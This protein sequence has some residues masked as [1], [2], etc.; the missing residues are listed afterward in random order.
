M[1]YFSRSLF[2]TLTL[3]SIVRVSAQD[4][5]SV[6]DAIEIRHKAEDMVK[7]QLNVLMNALTSKGFDKHETIEAIHNSFSE[8]RRIFRDSLIDVEPDIDPRIKTSEDAGDERLFK[9]LKDLDVMYNKT[10]GD[11]IQISNISCSNVKKRENIYIKVYFNSLMQGKAVVT[12]QAYT[13]TN[14]V[15]EIMARKDENQWHLYIVRLG[16]FRPTDTVGDILNN[17]PVRFETNAFV[18]LTAQSTASDSAAAIQRQLSIEEAQMAKTTKQLREEDD[19]RDKEFAKLL[20]QGDEAN[21]KRD[22]N[23]AMKYYGEAQELKP[24]SDDVNSRLKATK[25]AMDASVLH[26]EVL[27][28]HYIRQAQLQQKNHQYKEAYTSYINAQNEN[29]ELGA[30]YDSIRD[31]M[32]SKY[33]T[34]SN[35]QDKYDAGQY[36]EAA[37]EYEEYIKKD[38][39]NSD[40]YLGRGRCYVKMSGDKKMTNKAL[41]DFTNAI[42]YDPYNLPAYSS[43]ADLYAQIGDY[44]KAL[45][46]YRF[47]LTIDSSNI[48]MYIRKSEMHILLKRPDDAITDLDDALQV[49]PQAAAIFLK[50][51]L[52]L[53]DR[54]ETGKALDNF[55]SAIRIDSTIALA[56]FY[57]GRCNI[58]LNKASAAAGDFEQARGYRLDS[59]NIKTIQEY[60][61]AYY[62][63]AEAKF[64]GNKTDSA[65][66][67][68]NT[69]IALYPSSSVYR[70]SQGEYY[71]SLQHYNEAINSYNE[72]IKRNDAFKDA[73]YKRGLAC[74]KL[75]SYQDAI[76]NFTAFLKLDPS[77][78][79]VLKANGDAYFSLRDFANAAVNYENAMKIGVTQKNGLPS[80]LGAEICNALGKSYFEVADYD[81]A[82]QNF[83]AAVRFNKSLPEAYFNLGYTF[84]KMNQLSDAL[85]NLQKALESGEKH[86]QWNYVLAKA[87]QEKRDY[88]NAAN[89]YGRCIQ[90]DTLSKWQD[91]VY[92]EGYC[93]YLMQNYMDALPLYTRS[94][95]LHL[96][97]SIAA[98][99]IE[100][101]TIYL[102][103][104]KYDSGYTCFHL[105]YEKDNSNGFASYGIACVMA[106]Q[107]KHVEA[108]SWFDKSFQ[109]KS[110][111]LAEMKKDKLLAN[112]RSDKDFK[113]LL[114]KYYSP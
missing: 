52:L 49:N 84:Y 22:Y 45:S 96:D 71:F 13:L 92:L 43:R 83:K 88:L 10:E 103:V 85:V 25:A 98:F 15:A 33:R 27:F 90:Q 74:Y 105:A 39:T 86:A 104:G 19:R 2:L 24:T 55:T 66:I 20:Q 21:R 70:F 1:I 9:Y 113:A 102:N 17:M 40:Y 23:L 38:R 29:P 53:Y 81:K 28:K 42:K 58:L 26:S 69:A 18:G 79:I 7:S 11:S 65:L 62:V 35:L 101:G 111:S 82:L 61:Q 5:L 97:T 44:L 16:F 108:L 51:G 54:N 93:Y 8:E 99:P 47:Y 114:K 106:M 31:A 64:N 110:V 100:L 91:A 12:N 107:G 95:V 36:K 87:C 48:D 3:F 4:S 30:R 109:T 46:D 112:I 34:L 78:V 59:E 94:Q 63:R 80:P 73:Y 32:F 56:W 50:K 67:L 76:D 41:E 77:Q 72:A 89:Q 57:R 75:R 68:V 6:K 14:R 60:A 37:D